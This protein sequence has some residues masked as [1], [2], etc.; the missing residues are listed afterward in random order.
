MKAE[1]RVEERIQKF[2]S[3]GVVH[4]LEQEEEPA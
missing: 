1:K 2:A 4:D 3:M